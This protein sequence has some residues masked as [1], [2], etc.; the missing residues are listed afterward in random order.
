MPT[1]FRMLPAS[2]LIKSH[3]TKIF[4]C[5]N[6]DR[7]P[8]YNVKLFFYNDTGVIFNEQAALV[9]AAGGSR[10]EDKWKRFMLEKPKMFTNLKTAM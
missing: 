5:R 4:I 10:K 8:I 9:T 7:M 1:D 3:N 6:Q 2:I